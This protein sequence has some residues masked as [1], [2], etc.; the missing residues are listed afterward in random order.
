MRHAPFAAL[1]AACLAACAGGP[2]KPDA[3]PAANARYSFWRPAPV[4][5]APDPNKIVQEAP[6]EAWRRVDPDRKSVV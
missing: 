6:P 4:V 2:A 3:E 5:D 1:A